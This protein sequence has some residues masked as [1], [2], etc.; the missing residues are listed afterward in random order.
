MHGT[1]TI[2][3]I[4]SLAACGAMSVNACVSDDVVGGNPKGNGSVDAT[5]PVPPVVDGG[6]VPDAEARTDAAGP[7][8]PCATSVTFDGSALDSG[9]VCG[10]GD[11]RKFF[12]QCAD[13]SVCTT[14]YPAEDPS[15][16]V[17]NNCNGTINEGKPNAPSVSTGYTCISCRTS[18]EVSRKA[19]GGV[20]R[21]LGTT[22]NDPRCVNT[23]LCGVGG[24][25]WVR[26][27]TSPTD[28]AEACSAIGSRC[29]EACAV[30]S[31]E[32]AFDEG[33]LGVYFSYIQC[34]NGFNHLTGSCTT[35]SFGSYSVKNQ[36]TEQY[37]L[38]CCCDI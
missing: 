34:I 7:L 21:I 10:A 12:A 38:H 8:S 3:F 13:A 9:V 28:C 1:Q 25:R 19:D 22:K 23:E 26:V 35:Q 31:P 32:C 36:G 5:T 37:N 33:G 18:M 20:E 11:C 17:D 27:V 30:T 14:A 24:P 6:I 15:D 2:L 29:S 4:L 16:A